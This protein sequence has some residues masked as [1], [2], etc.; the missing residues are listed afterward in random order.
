MATIFLLSFPFLSPCGLSLSFFLL[1]L[2]LP[3]RL[4]MAAQK[5]VPC[6]ECGK[7]Y[8]IDYLN[9]Y[10][11]KSHKSAYP[12]NA[13]KCDACH[14][15]FNDFK[16]LNFHR[17]HRNWV[18]LASIFFCIQIRSCTCSEMDARKIQLF[19]SDS[20]FRAGCKKLWRAKNK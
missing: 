20:L 3:L 13:Y 18:L 14:L 17:K 7:E 19:S 8:N 12:S 15:G 11:M 5:K 2:L 9:N 10:H 6:L 1:L 16:E 4:S